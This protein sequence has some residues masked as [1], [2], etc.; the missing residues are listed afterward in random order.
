VVALVAQPM[1]QYMSINEIDS[2]MMATAMAVR[3]FRDRSRIGPGG[4]GN[5]LFCFTLK[6]IQLEG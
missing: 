4:L 5:Q 6:P 2:E 1:S 3:G